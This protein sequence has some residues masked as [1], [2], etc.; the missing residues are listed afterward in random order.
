MYRV[1]EFISA[2]M[3]AGTAVVAFGLRSLA[4]FA[5]TLPKESFGEAVAMR[6]P[7][8]TF[9]VDSHKFSSLLKTDY[10][11]RAVVSEKQTDSTQLLAK[12]L[13]TSK[14][15]TSHGTIFVTDFQTAGLNACYLCVLTQTF[16]FR[17]RKTRS[18]LAKRGGRKLAFQLHLV[19]S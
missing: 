11:G 19:F 9:A 10:L 3:F 12:N 15:E 6:S 17:S 14:G 4:S 13:F 7:D 5:K 2:K 8:L 16:I 18:Q 1:L